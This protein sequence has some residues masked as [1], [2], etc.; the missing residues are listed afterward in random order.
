MKLMYLFSKFCPTTITINLAAFAISMTNLEAILKLS[1]Y[2][3]AI[4]WTSIRI[5]K[6]LKNWNNKQ[7]NKD[8]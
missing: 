2:A 6:E 4:I 1:S 8:A 7:S 3:V 5:A